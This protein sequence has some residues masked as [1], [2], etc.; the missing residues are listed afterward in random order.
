MGRGPLFR[1]DY[2][3]QFSGHE[4]FPLRYGW[5][6]KAFDAVAETG[7]PE[8][9]K[10]VFLSDGAI[11]KF[12]V[13]RN[14]VS[15]MRHWAV[16]AGVLEESGDFKQI[17]PTSVGKLLFGDEGIDP[18]LE[19]PSS[20]W[21]IHW[22]LA[23]RP[24][25]TTWFWVFNHYPAS[26]FERETLAKGLLALAEERQW[27]RIA[28]STI[29]RDV[30]CFVRSYAVR[31]AGGTQRHEDLLESPLIELGLVRALGKRDGFR[32]ERGMK[33]T[34][35]DGVF[36]YALIDFWSRFSSARTL[37]FEALA[38]E[39][40]A[41]GRTFLL[42]EEDLADRL[43][44]LDELTSGALRWSETAGLKQVIRN[45]DLDRSLALARIEFEAKGSTRRKAA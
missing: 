36:L 3:P 9:A 40:G 26:S 14:M 6:K 41:P 5:L 19:R 24:E 2:R 29:K 1:A 13:G 33:P 45:R 35:S 38:Y 10:A 34:L 27:S 4:T 39:P 37:S 31:K 23:G 22:N 30:E 8:A 21:L 28:A 20:L 18:Y 15:A 25:K 11:G 42:D 16:A 17:R 44:G 7:S 43:T 32:L 12:G